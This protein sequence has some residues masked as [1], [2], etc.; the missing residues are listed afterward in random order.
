MHSSS[1]QEW[2]PDGE[3][4]VAIA[5]LFARRGWLSG[6]SDAQREVILSE[7]R[8]VALERGQRLIAAGDGPGGIYGVVSGGIG[9]EGTTTWHIPRLGHVF[10]PGDWF[11]HGPIL[12]GG[13]RTM[14]YVALEA[15]RLVTVPLAALRALVADRPDIGILVGDMANRGTELGAWVA[16]DLLIPEAPRRMAAVLLRV[17]AA[18]D[19]VKPSNAQGFPL[20][21][22][23]LAE[24]SNMSPHTVNRNLGLLARRGWITKSYNHVQVLDVA[25]LSAFAYGEDGRD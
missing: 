20:T 23:M 13:N 17:T 3:A 6:A 1:L 25:G 16:C 10:R 14:G 18:H 5:A 15:S 19:G 12:N 8:N 2:R 24:M 21:Q 4:K 22:A 11:G 7:C 9:G